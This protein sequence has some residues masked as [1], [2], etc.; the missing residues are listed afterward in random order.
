[1]CV[2]EVAYR[3]RALPS[4]AASAESIPETEVSSRLGLSLAFAAGFRHRRLVSLV[5]LAPSTIADSIRSSL[6]TVHLEASRLHSP[7][8][9]LLGHVSCVVELHHRT[10]YMSVLESLLHV[11][12]T[13]M[14]QSSL[15]AIP[16]ALL[17]LM[18]G[19]RDEYCDD[20]Q[21]QALHRSTQSLA[22]CR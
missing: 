13:L 20:V 14:D 1:M 17:R 6:H 12:V 18:P 22:K 11:A 9:R 16:R 21:R 4:F 5:K 7:K 3:C 19:W 2:V 15:L 8:L 10:A